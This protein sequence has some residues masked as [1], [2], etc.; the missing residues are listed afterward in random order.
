MLFSE[1]GKSLFDTWVFVA[2]HHVIRLLVIIISK[3]L[4][5]YLFAGGKRWGEVLAEYLNNSMLAKTVFPEKISA[6]TITGD[7]FPLRK[8]AIESLNMIEIIC[9]EEK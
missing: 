1:G 3:L 8:V 6:H 7:K 5:F 9:A 4:F 2:L